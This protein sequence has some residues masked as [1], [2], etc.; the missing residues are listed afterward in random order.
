M[1]T[2][3]YKIH[4]LFFSTICHET[5]RN[6]YNTRQDLTR[7]NTHTRKNRHLIKLVCRM[8][9][10][11]VVKWFDFDWGQNNI[12][13][14]HN[15]RQFFTFL[16][17]FFVKKINSKAGLFSFNLK[18]IK[19]V[20]LTWTV[21]LKCQS[22]FLYIKVHDLLRSNVIFTCYVDKAINH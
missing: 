10:E 21:K 16:F 14:S 18:T 7:L 20:V 6:R 2:K 17:A 5:R 15:F 13:F 4:H 1:F 12:F 9:W 3:I 11:M 8:N 22:R 19:F